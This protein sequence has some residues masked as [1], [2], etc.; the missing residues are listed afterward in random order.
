MSDIKTPYLNGHMY[1]FDLCWLVEKILS[2]ESQLNQAIDLKTIHYA[3][4]IQWD[5]TTQYAPNT[6]V[7]DSKTGT[8]YMSKVPVPA[9]ILLGN[10]DYWVVIFNYQKIYTKI[11]EGVA[12]YNGQSDLASK[13]L[14]VNDL[15]WY[16]L[17]LYRV[18]RAIDEG[19]KLI[20]GTNLVKTSIESLLSN[21]YGRDR[22]TTL[23]NDTLNVSGDYTVNAGDISITSN[24][25]TY[26]IT[27]DAEVDAD[28]TVNIKAADIALTPDNPL[29]YG[30]P[31][32][33]DDNFNFVSFKSLDNNPYKVL[34]YKNPVLSG[35]NELK[36]GCLILNKLLDESSGSCTYLKTNDNKFILFD[37][38]NPRVYDDV[39]T[40]LKTAGCSKIDAIVISHYD[41]D[42][43][44][45]PAFFKND[46]DMSSCIF[47]LP[48]ISSVYPDSSRNQK[49]F[50]DAY[51]TNIFIYPDNLSKY[52]FSKD[53]SFKFVN[54]G[55]NVI[56]YYDSQ[57]NIPYNNYSMVTTV[58]HENDILLFPGDVEQIA[59]DYIYNQNWAEE[60]DFM[61]APHHGYDAGV[62]CQPLARVWRPKFIFVPNNFSQN[63]ETGL[64]S[65]MLALMHNYGAIISSATSNKSPVEI[66]STGHG[67]LY[68]SYT[69]T[70]INHYSIEMVSDI[71][72]DDTYKGTIRNGNAATPYGSLIEAINS[73]NGYP[74]VIH[75]VH[76][77]SSKTCTLA[78]ALN[79][80]IDFNNANIKYLAMLNCTNCTIKNANI[81]TTT[82]FSNSYG[83]R[84]INIKFNTT[85]TIDKCELYMESITFLV[86]VDIGLIVNMSTVV[87]NALSGTFTK[88]GIKCTYSNVTGGFS[89]S[90]VNITTETGGMIWAQYSNVNLS[91]NADIATQLPKAWYVAETHDVPILYDITN[92]KP[93]IL[94]DTKTLKYLSFEKE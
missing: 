26:K 12:F 43:M 21:Y 14:L 40:Q 55:T 53:V 75:V 38:G 8:A 24:N 13:A 91:R 29:T 48:V 85:T 44:S 81:T 25:L 33:L 61:V 49:K 15:V 20:P 1:E 9:G 31:Q 51:P 36:I 35:Y 5:I 72:V 62:F 42:H 54:C 27:K 7:V 39:K 56:N 87:L 2:F 4:P 6:V 52:D 76:L 57:G 94:T 93:C 50:T 90:A 63:D 45:D 89:Y 88:C 11:M 73:C 66:Y 65:P 92:S 32:S 58:Y 34:V 47:Y 74:T 17:D 67:L 78:Y 84:L 71:Y 10:T 3:D 77:S 69:N 23:L 46:F 82:D 30:R 18:T 37:L 19:G 60:C 70:L 41:L 16:G 68:G 86:S 83:C 79:V 59:M 64:R 22:V 28:G 80:T